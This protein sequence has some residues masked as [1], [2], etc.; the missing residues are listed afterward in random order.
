MPCSTWPP[1][2]WPGS[3]FSPA[4]LLVGRCFH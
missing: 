4:L 2:W 3:T 1:S